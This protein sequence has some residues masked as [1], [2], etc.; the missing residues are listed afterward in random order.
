MQR[1]EWLHKCLNMKM[2]WNDDEV[3][4]LIELSKD[5]PLLYDITSPT[6]RNWMV[7]RM[8]R[9]GSQRHLTKNISSN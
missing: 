6:Y 9:E 3:F 4:V 5:T 1:W 8:Q 2:E 7:G